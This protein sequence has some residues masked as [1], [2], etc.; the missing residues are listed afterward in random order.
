MNIEVVVED[1][2]LLECFFSCVLYELSNVRLDD[3]IHIVV[4]E[5]VIDGY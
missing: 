4:V 5:V 1:M 3:S 2:Q